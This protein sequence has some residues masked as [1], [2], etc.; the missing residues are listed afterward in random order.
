M[1]KTKIAFA[2]AISLLFSACHDTQIYR[3]T[4]PELH[5]IAIETVIGTVGDEMNRII[6]LDEDRYGRKL[7]AYLGRAYF[8]RELDNPYSLAII[9]AQKTNDQYAFYYDANNYI[10]V[11]IESKYNDLDEGKVYSHFTQDEI[12]TLKIT[13]EWDQPINETRLF[14][15]DVLRKKKYSQFDIRDLRPF[16]SK[17]EGEILNSY[18]LCYSTDQNGKTIL[19]VMTKDK[20]SKYRN[21]LVMLERDGNLVSE[22]SIVEITDQF[23][24]TNFIKDFKISNDW[25]FH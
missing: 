18:I 9:I 21:Y 2:I 16:V 14:R 6:V 25:A 5:I 24:N 23:E 17:F 7:F 22:K 1:N 10:V 4:F 3:G 20:N 8:N 11:T 19:A 12:D 15:L 13:N